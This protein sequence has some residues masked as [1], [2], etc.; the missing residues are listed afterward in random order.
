GRLTAV[1]LSRCHCCTKTCKVFGNQRHVFEYDDADVDGHP[2]RG[3][4][5][6]LRVPTEPR[7]AFDH[8]DAEPCI[9]QPHCRVSTGGTTTNHAHVSFDYVAVTTSLTS[10]KRR[11]YSPRGSGRHR[12]PHRSFDDL[13]PRNAL[14]LVIT[15]LVITA[16]VITALVITA[17]R[18]PPLSGAPHVTRR[19]HGLAQWS[20]L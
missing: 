2:R 20:M 17:H 16:L 7:L 1:K 13:T 11:P 9:A 19:P 10:G 6:G 4:E 5:I 12:F 8:R 14:T 3:I 18:S 15:A